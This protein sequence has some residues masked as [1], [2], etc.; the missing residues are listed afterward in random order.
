FEK[1][2][3][4][5]S[6]RRTNT[7]WK[8]E[9]VCF[10]CGQK[11]HFASECPRKKHDHEGSGGKRRSAKAVITQSKPASPC[12]TTFIWASNYKEKL[13]TKLRK[14]QRLKSTTAPLSLE[15][16]DG[17][18][19]DLREKV[20]LKAELPPYQ[21]H[22][23]LCFAFEAYVMSMRGTSQHEL[24]IGFPSIL[25]MDLFNHMKV[26]SEDHSKTVQ[27][28]EWELE[29]L[30]FK[31]IEK[32][33]QMTL[34][35]GIQINQEFE[36]ELAEVL[37][38]I[39]QQQSERRMSV[40]AMD[41]Q[42][43]EGSQFTLRSNRRVPRA[44]QEFL[45]REIR[46]LLDCGTISHSSSPYH[47][48][49]VIVPKKGGKL[50]L[51][52]DFR[53]LNGITVPLQFPLPRLDDC[54]EGLQGQ[55]IFGTLDL[56]KGFHQI[57]LT[58]S[59]S[60]L[61]AFRTP[62]GIFQYNT[63]PFGLVN[64]PSFFQQVMTHVFDGLIGKHCI[65]YIDDI[66]IFGRTIDT[67]VESL[68]LVLERINRFSLTLNREKCSLGMRQI[69]FLGFL[70][71]AEGRTICP[72]R[73]KAIKNIPEPTSKKD[74]RSFLGLINFV[75][76]FIPECASISHNLY[77]LTEKDTNF[78]WT[79]EHE[80]SF[81]RLK[82][83]ISSAAT[84]SFPL[85]EGELRLFTDA[86][87]VG[88]GGALL[89]LSSD[90]K[91]KPI[92]F[93]SKA[94][95]A[96]QRRCIDSK[97]L[98]SVRIRL[99][100]DTDNQLFVEL[101]KL[102]AADPLP[103]EEKHTIDE[104]GLVVLPSG[105][106]Y[107]PEKKEFRL[108]CIEHAH[109]SLIAADPLPE[110]EKHTID[111]L[112]LVVLPS[113]FLYIPEQKEFRLKCIEH[114]HSSLIGGHCGVNA[115]LRRL[116]RWRI[117]WTNIKRDISK[118]VQECLVCQRDRLKINWK[119]TKGCTFV[120]KPFF[121]IAV[122]A[123]GPFPESYKGCKYGLSFI[124]SF[125]RYIEI[126]PTKTANAEEAAEILYHEYI[127]RFGVPEIIKSDNGK[128]FVNSLWEHL[129]KWLGVKHRKTTVY[130]PQSNGIVERSNRELLKFL[131]ALIAEGMDSRNWD[132]SFPLIRFLMNNQEH[133]VLGVTPF[134]MVFGRRADEV[135][136]LFGKMTRKSPADVSETCS[137]GNK[138]T[139]RHS[140]EYLNELYSRLDA[141]K[142]RLVDL[143]KERIIGSDPNDSPLVQ[144]EAF[145]WLKPQK[146]TSKLSSRLRGPFQVV[147]NLGKNMVTI[148]N[149][150]DGKNSN[151]HLR[152][153]IEVKGNHSFEQLKKMAGLS[154]GEYFI[155][156]IENHRGEDQ[157]NLEFFVHWSGYEE[158]ENT[159]EPIDEVRDSIAMEDYLGEHPE[160]R[161]LVP[162]SKDK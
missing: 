149:I 114:A 6:D 10:N 4:K 159:W 79:K 52:V 129:L 66:I 141:L 82:E 63:M 99:T 32:V 95:N 19:L 91:M 147:G 27:D 148:K 150:L 72:D 84:L 73:V 41:I 3:K 134:E 56:A 30:D 15:L 162:E 122:D 76:D 90:A 70:I 161:D 11:G 109:S 93:V 33:E 113:G 36:S 75:R 130:N 100:Y 62:Q 26:S 107:I 104:L 111:E 142:K 24:V 160:L 152:R 42:L 124:D 38:D 65:V 158:S 144:P 12:L 131:R 31:R 68:K 138:T 102:Q 59:A 139:R 119:E 103:E 135:F 67:F 23:A 128:Q 156:S 136:D 53:I 54:L 110:E 126:F 25:R 87:D 94:L 29:E 105:F 157:T 55:K 133:S 145:V 140:T 45:K 117:V 8:K 89:Q 101:K 35:N 57:P 80:E 120:D 97:R 92:A 153:L 123:I 154:D 20:Q 77:E 146:K 85:D 108:K 61:T 155:E 43:V 60:M 125:T 1:E 17:S 137:L 118:F 21:D 49:I 40:P 83:L 127:L 18:V 112:G 14:T 48:P 115:T 71:S 9:I 50:R 116:K 16:A 39:S 74:V 64:A 151:V 44:H 58:E 88:I 37:D 78:I 5:F 2:R 86:S 69:E 28:V 47:S 143:Q 34:H 81:S 132:E 7:D 46:E 121:S 51:C 22:K 106:L 96:V 13:Y 98:N